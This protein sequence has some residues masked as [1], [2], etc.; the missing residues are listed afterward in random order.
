MQAEEILS[1]A[2]TADDADNWA[3]FPL[4]RS[5]I[6]QAI[7]GWI[8]G[9]LI[10]GAIL[11][12][13]LPIVVPYN[14][15]HGAFSIIL[16]SLFLG[17]LLFIAIGSACLLI[18]D[19]RRL[20]QADRHIIVITHEDFIKQEGQKIIHVP[21]SAVRHVTPRGRAPLDRTPP[22]SSSETLN[23]MPR[24]GQGILGL[25]LGRNLA[26]S[27]TGASQ[28]R[29]RMRTPTSLAFIDTRTETEVTVVN[30]NA[31]GDPFAISAVLKEYAATKK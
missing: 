23:E 20:L 10:G 19:I 3:V 14:Y 15:Q 4:L 29:K 11:A 26:A 2:K 21:L 16:T 12:F 22:P 8:F 25:F 6:I 31:Y 17:M 28:R 1:R 27:A 13:M 5:K 9:I 18:I 24:P 7:I 30:D